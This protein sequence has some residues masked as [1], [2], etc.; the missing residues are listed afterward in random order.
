MSIS[1]QGHPVYV[2]NE[3]ITPET[4]R[5]ETDRKDEAVVRAIEIIP[6]HVG[7][8]ERHVKLK[9]KNGALEFKIKYK[10]ACGEGMIVKDHIKLT[11]GEIFLHKVYL[12]HLEA[13]SV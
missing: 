4:F 13:L 3:E 2:K 8:Y 9:V 1:S 10:S 11:S 12:I 6:A 5:V 7:D